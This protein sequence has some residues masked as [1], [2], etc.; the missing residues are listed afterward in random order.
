[1]KKVLIFTALLLLLQNPI[2]I[3]Q[4]EYKYSETTTNE[5]AIKSLERILIHS[6]RKTRDNQ[7]KEAITD[8]DGLLL[9]LGTIDNSSAR[10]LLL[11]LLE[12]YFGSATGEALSHAVLIQ[13]KKIRND[14]L[15]LKSSPVRCDLLK[16][17]PSEKH[18]DPISCL[19][20]KSRD[21][22]VQRLIDLINEDFIPQYVY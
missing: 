1:M 19:D 14:L 5:I 18:I 3:G 9:L 8:P 22:R 21:S 6:L 2:V 15:K 12:L 13:G 7:Y 17:Y 4:P 16:E 10:R 20:A 11:D